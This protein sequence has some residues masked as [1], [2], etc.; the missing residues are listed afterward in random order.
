MY[1]CCNLHQTTVCCWT[2]L[3][4]ICIPAAARGGDFFLLSG[5]RSAYDARVE[6]ID[7]A[8]HEINLAYY[9]IDSG[10]AA[11]SLLSRL[12]LAA[13]R[14]VKVRILVDGLMTRLPSGIVSLLIQEGIELREYHP[15]LIGRPLWLNR[16]LHYKL[17][18]VD[19]RAM[20][21]GS[22]NLEDAHF[23]LA[24]EN[25]VDIDALL[26]GDVCRSATEHF[27]SLWNSA[28]VVPVTRKS[29][30]NSA[31]GEAGER[32]ILEATR[33]I[34]ARDDFADHPYA[35]ETEPWVENIATT[36]LVHDC[37]TDKSDRH[38]QSRVIAMIDSAQ[39][40]VWIET[41]YPVLER[42]VKDALQRANG[43]GAN[44]ILQ[45]NSLGT[46]DRTAPYAAYQHDKREY[47]R[48]GVQLVEYSGND[49]LHSKVV[50]IDDQT[51]L[52]GSY[53]MDARSDRL[54][55]EFA[56][57]IDD[58]RVCR[59]VE[60]QLLH[61][62]YQGK[63]VQKNRLGLPEVIRSDASLIKNSQ[64]RFRQAWVPFI[65]GWL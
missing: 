20:I 53:N 39:H 41:P 54:N 6:L 28:D 18:V 46:I 63:Q 21:V 19:G 15:T 14:G 35:C 16:R 9:S 48:L 24:S 37:G 47:L 64:M 27:L 50:L 12:R 5:N 34:A 11:L 33:R 26:T 52:L 8:Q 43:R 7:L 31:T 58:K 23:G 65:R 61:R 38:F 25:F 51:V 44:V 62:R 49:T 56:V 42:P 60:Q 29:S 30:L 55:L 3:V 4:L 36:V 17:L 13:N 1:R 59:V 2:W 32:Q 10:D 57:R 40:R 22:R 45:T